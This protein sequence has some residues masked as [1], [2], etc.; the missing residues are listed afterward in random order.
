MYEKEGKT[1]RVELNAVEKHLPKVLELFQIVLVTFIIFESDGF[2]FV[3]AHK[4][5]KKKVGKN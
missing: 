2:H 4:E 1:L 5:N 3:K